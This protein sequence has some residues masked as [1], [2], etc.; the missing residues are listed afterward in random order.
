MQRISVIIPN[1]NGDKFIREC[2]NGVFNQTYSDYEVIVVDNG[3]MDQSI[4]IIINE[5]PNVKL[6][7]LQDNLG[8]SGGLNF[9]IK[10]AEGDFIALLHMDA[11][12]APNWLEE[13]LAVMEKDQNIFSVTPL[14]LK[15]D[16][17]RIIDNAGYAY[18]VFGSAYSIYEGKNANRV[19]LKNKCIFSACHCGGL[20]RT[21]MLHIVG[22]F[23]NEFFAY[24]EDVDIGWR[25]M[26]F[27]YK[28]VFC[29]DAVVMHLGNGTLGYRYNDFKT[30]L[31]SRNNLFL[32]YKNM[33][34]WQTAA[35]KP[36]ML[37]SRKMK[38][39][40]YGKKELKK[41]YRIGEAEAKKTRK[42]LYKVR[43]TKKRRKRQIFIGIQLIKYSIQYPF[44][45]RKIQ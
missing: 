6:I 41:F 13:M 30:R 35:F 10:K 40:I 44:I 32:L 28:N 39:R 21:S 37:L 29:T 31:T 14:I 7:P 5:Y 17:P 20:Y 26:L 33:P 42:N 8:I 2:L 16:K 45:R 12:P 43:Y 25:A 34:W 36:F 3:S 9:G 1:Y 23:D 24:L 15:K 18:T 4:D 38:K 22:G 19:K 27:G 11:V